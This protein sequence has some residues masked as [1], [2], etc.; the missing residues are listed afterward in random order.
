MTKKLLSF[1]AILMIVFAINVTA[2]SSEDDDDGGGGYGGGRLGGT[3]DT[4]VSLTN[5][6][7]GD[8]TSTF[9]STGSFHE[10]GTFSGI[11]AGTPPS[12]RTPEIGVWRHVRRREYEFRFK[13][14]F[15]S[16]ANPTGA[17]VG[18]QI[19]THTIQLN[20][21]NLNYTS[22]GDAKV[23]NMAGTQIGAG[24][25]TAVGTRMVLD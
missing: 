19:I 15:W 18:Y 14:Y 12:L 7:T 6:A 4:V 23:F 20:R 25:S 5:C 17:P 10:G 1:F 9:Q 8:V 13:A 11:T 22:A 16:P 21:D 3:W 2:Q 24:C